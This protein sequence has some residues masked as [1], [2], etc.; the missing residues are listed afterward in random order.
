M[1]NPPSYQSLLKMK[2]QQKNPSGLSKSSKKAQ[3]RK[4]RAKTEMSYAPASQGRI[5]RTQQ[6]SVSGSPYSGDGVVRVR[7]REYIAELAGSV[8]FSTVSF[9]IN[10]GLITLFTWLATLASQ[11]ESYIFRNLRIYYETEKPTSA[12]GGVQIAIDFNAADPAP[13]TKSALMAIHNA[14]RSAIWQEMCY[15]ADSKDLLKFGVQRFIRTAALAA[16]LD[17]KTYDLGNI[18]IGTMGMADT[19]SVGELYIEYDVELHTPQLNALAFP[20]AE[21]GLIAS[22]V[23]VTRT[24]IFGTAPV[25]T[26]GAGA[27]ASGQTITF[28]QVGQFLMSL[29]GVGTAMNANPP[30]LASATATTTLLT[31]FFDT[32]NLYN[33][34]VF[35]VNVTAAGQ[36]MV[37]A[38]WAGVSNTVTSTAVR[39]APYLYALG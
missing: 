32:N 18:I 14:V 16:N 9:S 29:I 10:P 13:T 5:M 1:S 31:T 21:A 17:I 3:K 8:G 11:F 33:G 22:A 4:T 7:H 25:I 30:A 27:T 15:E 12:A 35:L 24:A 28:N 34:E 37:F 2:N 19:S 20:Y 36:N 38:S 39:L 6:P 26:G 23:N